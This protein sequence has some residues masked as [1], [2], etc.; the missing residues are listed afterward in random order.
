MC[1]SVRR[2]PIPCVL[3]G[4]ALF[5]A[6]G[7]VALAQG[8]GGFASK[9]RAAA[10]GDELSRQP[11]LWVCEVTFKPMRL[12]RVDVTD[13][14]TGK[15]SREL[16]YY[17]C[18][19]AVNR[20]LG[21]KADEQNINPVNDYDPPPGK[22]MFVPEFTLVTDDDGKQEVYHDTVIPEAQAAILK[23]EQRRPGAP[24]LRNSVEVVQALPAAT[25]ADDAPGQTIWGVA[26]FRGVDPD[27]DNFS[28]FMSGF[29]NGYKLAKL[30]GTDEELVLRR[31][32][33]QD[34]WRPGDRFDQQ[35]TEIRAKGDPVWEYRPDDVKT[36]QGGEPVDETTKPAAKPAA[37]KKDDAEP[38][39]ATENN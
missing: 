23:R 36:T 12:M 24:R 16:V 6:C 37:E 25:N 20:P 3:L 18:Y 29:S 4:V 32:I 10:T 11:G 8:D 31:T 27:A 14:K 30:P 9:V 1:L 33:R 15:K 13:P 28:V 26:M 5:L 38:K 7:G 19:K 17:L 22:P 39:E 35:E 21:N 34:Y 2:K